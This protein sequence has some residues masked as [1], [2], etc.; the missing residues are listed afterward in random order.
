MSDND[1]SDE[2]GKATREQY[3]YRQRKARLARDKELASLGDAEA[4]ARVAEDQRQKDAKE[5]LR[6][7]RIAADPRTPD[8]RREA[9]R[10]KKAAYRARIREEEHAAQEREEQSAAQAAADEVAAELA[11]ERR[12]EGDRLRKEAEQRRGLATEAQIAAAMLLPPQVLTKEKVCESQTL[13]G[14]D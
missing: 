7:Q 6:K 10:L 2:N 1:E 8:E 3:R 9:E 14:P 11:R 12:R 5:A 13:S 4:A